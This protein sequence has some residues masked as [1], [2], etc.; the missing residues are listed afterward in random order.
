M[1][2]QKYLRQA[3]GYVNYFLVG[4]ILDFEIMKGPS[5][6]NFLTS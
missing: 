6:P 2:L 5:Q 1:Y 4:K 3:V